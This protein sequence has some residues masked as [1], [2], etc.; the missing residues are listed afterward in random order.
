MKSSFARASSFRVLSAL[1]TLVTY[2][3]TKESLARDAS[4]IRL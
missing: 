1:R 4:A 3:D 2:A